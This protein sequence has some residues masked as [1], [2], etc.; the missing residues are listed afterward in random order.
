V[1]VLHANTFVPAK[2]KQ[3]SN[4]TSVL[5]RKLKKNYTTEDLQKDL[6]DL[7]PT[8]SPAHKPGVFCAVSP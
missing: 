7:I 5:T 6:D 4:T 1:L 8:L 3:L 2:E